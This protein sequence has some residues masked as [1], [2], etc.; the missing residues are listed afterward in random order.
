MDKPQTGHWLNYSGEVTRPGGTTSPF[1]LLIIDSQDLH[2]TLEFV[3]YIDEVGIKPYC[4]PPH[5][6]HLLQTLDVGL[7]SPLQKAYGK[8][9]DRISRFSFF[10]TWKWNS[11][12]LLVEARDAS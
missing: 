11:L 8:A 5:S 6:T 1:C 4:L 3:K 9:M 2:I 10:S 7:L 12:P